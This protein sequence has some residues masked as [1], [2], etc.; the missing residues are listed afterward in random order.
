[1]DSSEIPLAV[2]GQAAKLQCHA[3][4]IVPM[5]CIM[6]VAFSSAAILTKFC[7]LPAA[8]VG[9]WRVLGA[10]LVL[11][12]WFITTARQ[13]RPRPL[14]SW[15][16]VFTG[17]FLGLHFG[18]WAWALLHGKV[19]NAALFLAMQPAITPALGHIV[20]RDRL[21]A[22]EYLGTAL[23]CAGM[24]F[25]LGTQIACDR[26]ELPA[27][28]V[29]LFSMLCCVVYLVLT[30]KFR[31]KEHITLFSVPVYLA[32]AGIQLVPALLCRKLLPDSIGGWAAVAGMILVPTVGGH[33]LAMYL[34]KHTKAHTIALSV[35]VQ[36]IIIT[37]AGM[38][39]F[40]QWPIGWFYPGAVLVV[41]GVLLAITAGAKTAD[42]EDLAAAEVPEL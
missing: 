7:G 17:I 2:D 37:V 4:Q 5:W 10:G 6:S 38:F 29:A 21:N 11:M 25:V 28:L 39:L 12:P 31:T 41:A 18:T 1:M 15:G 34:L 35:P 8:S 16:A 14:V 30:R 13:V 32:A 23:S 3:A 19:A 26:K 9:F 22:K 42:K 20:S 27:S 36:L 33:T 40:D 24:I